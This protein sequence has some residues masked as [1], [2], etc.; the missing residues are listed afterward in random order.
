MY[1]K[2]GL[3][4]VAQSFEIVLQRRIISKNTKKCRKR[5]QKLKNQVEISSSF[6]LL[7]LEAE[8]LT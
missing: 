8:L 5:F 6:L 1:V 7:A 2:V 4:T 3:P